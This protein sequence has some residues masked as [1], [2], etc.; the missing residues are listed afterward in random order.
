MGPMI[1][2]E[3]VLLAGRA[4]PVGALAV[5]AEMPATGL[6]DGDSGSAAR[7]AGPY[8]PILP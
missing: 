1:A 5:S 2:R 3:I 4:P 8:E 6:K 7:T